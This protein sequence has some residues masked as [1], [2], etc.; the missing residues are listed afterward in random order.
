LQAKDENIAGRMIVAAKKIADDL[1]ISQNGY[2]LL[3]RVKKHGGQEINHIH[4][5]LL[6]GAPLS[7]DIRPI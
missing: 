5:H 1:N 6:G 2:K 3:F 7:E 4:L